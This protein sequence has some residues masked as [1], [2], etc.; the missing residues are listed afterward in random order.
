MRNRSRS[1]IVIVAVL[2]IRCG[3]G[4]D[5]DYTSRFAGTWNGAIAN[6]FGDGTPQG[7]P[8]SEQLDT[9]GF[10]RLSVPGMCAGA[11]AKID[12]SVWA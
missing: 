6:D 4:L 1:A 9:A 7:I 5:Q 11:T 12:S 2:S 10:N 3:G 8:T